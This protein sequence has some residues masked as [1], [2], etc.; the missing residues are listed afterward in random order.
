MT[1]LS[2]EEFQQCS[3]HEIGLQ[4]TTNGIRHHIP[5]AQ[6]ARWEEYLSIMYGHNRDQTRMQT[7]QAPALTP[8]PP[9]IPTPAY[10]NYPTYQ[11]QPYQYQ[12]PPTSFNTVSM[13]SRTLNTILRVVGRR[14]ETPNT[15]MRLPQF[16]HD[17]RPPPQYNNHGRGTYQ[18][19]PRGGGLANRRGRRSDREGRIGIGQ[20]RYLNSRPRMGEEAT[21]IPTPATSPATQTSDTGHQMTAEEIAF[22]H[23]FANQ[24]LGSEGGEAIEVDV[25]MNVTTA[26]EEI[27]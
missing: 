19:G 16:R 8:T 4:A 13:P 14:P 23:K 18:R 20:T 9:P 5:S 26:N 22:L 6:P 25:P 21:P 2:P 11:Y 10:P 15:Y 12:P 24:D 7:F 3:Q 27:N 1:G 17:R